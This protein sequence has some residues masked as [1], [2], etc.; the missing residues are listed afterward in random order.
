VLKFEEYA[1]AFEGF[2]DTVILNINRPVRAQWFPGACSCVMIILLDDKGEL[3]ENAEVES[4]ELLLEDIQGPDYASY[5]P[6]GSKSHITEKFMEQI[7]KKH[8][9]IIPLIS[10][11]RKDLIV[12][13]EFADGDKV[14]F[15]GYYN[16]MKDWYHRKFKK[17]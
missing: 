1:F 3:E 11:I 7:N 10:F 9:N 5:G 15:E 13:L 8:S 12:T 14:V 4:I 6:V 17:K 2:K 16:E